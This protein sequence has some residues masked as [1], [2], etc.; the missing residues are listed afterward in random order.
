[1]TRTI[2]EHLVDTLVQAGV[3]QIYDERMKDE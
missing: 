2:G 3:R 1:M